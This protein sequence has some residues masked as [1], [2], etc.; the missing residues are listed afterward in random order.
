[1][2]LSVQA[3]A[4]ERPDDLA[5]IAA[6]VQ[7]SYRQLAARVCAAAA[8]L[9]ERG[10]GSARS[11]G[12]LVAISASNRPETL[13]V[14]LAL[15]ELGVPFVPL[16]PRWTAR[17]IDRVIADA[18][19][20]CVLR[21]DDMDALCAPRESAAERAL[22]PP[23]LSESATL[24]VLYTSGTAGAPKGAQL[25]RQAFLASA[26][27]SAQRLGWRDEDRW[28]LCLP[29]CHIGGLSIVTRCLLARRPIVLLPR[30]HAGEVLEAIE[31]HRATLL[32]V[33]PTMLHG[34]LAEDRSGVLS[35][36]RAVISGGAAT[37][38]P[39][40]ERAVASGVNVLTTYGLTEACSQVT[41]QP[42]L[43]QPCARRG[44]GLPLPGVELT[45]RGDDDQPLPPGAVGRICLRGPTLMSGYLHRAPLGDALFDTGDLGELD[46]EGTL[47]VHARRQDLI[48]TG[49]E[50]VYPA[51]VEQAL[52]EIEGVAAALVFGVP[53]PIWGAE[54]AAALVPGAGCTAAE[55]WARLPQALDGTLA[56]FKRPRRLAIV[57]SLPELAN[58]K[59]DRRRAAELFTERLVALPR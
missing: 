49:G 14:L 56:R 23:V 54:V 16:H 46:A 37:P 22:T 2:A 38:L 17:E 58:G 39:L 3:A 7:L 55:L 52:L 28:L 26:A 10:L 48:I 59:L 21:D 19:P 20:S 18:R 11:S 27:G 5:L 4:R 13:F 50:N 33:V 51:E 42:W 40:L 35:R 36:L 31:R 30:F 44:T 6:G 9:A 53:E 8:A 57:E 41:L 25:P 15:V 12:E 24:A 47:Y 32:S 43:P 1:M 29:L 45:L 34:L